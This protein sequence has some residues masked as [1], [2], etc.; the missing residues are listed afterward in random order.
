[1]KYAR[2]MMLVP[3]VSHVEETKLQ[4][5]DHEMN[6]I[7]NKK[8]KKDEKI[9]LYNH[10]LSKFLKQYDPKTSGIAPAFIELI[11]KLESFLDSQSSKT[12]QSQVPANSFLK[13][14]SLSSVSSFLPKSS[15]EEEELSNFKDDSSEMGS[16]E[17]LFQKD[18]IIL[19]KSRE[20]KPFDSPSFEM[21]K[22]KREIF[23]T[24]IKPRVDDVFKNEKNLDDIDKLYETVEGNIPARNTRSQQP[25]ASH[26]EGL[27]GPNRKAT[28]INTSASS[29]KKFS[30]KNG[31]NKQSGNSLWIRKRFF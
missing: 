3:Y 22:P 31:K 24:P 7:L 5:L 13:N 30:K 27:Q 11:K 12:L 28:S 18:D 21:F 29:K 14:S 17:E 15:S 6:D 16:K 1:M 26:S 8:S 20:L 25:D 23:R 10:S 4:E 2:K 9:K 19:P